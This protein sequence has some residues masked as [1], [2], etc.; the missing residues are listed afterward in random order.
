[1]SAALVARDT[2]KRLNMSINAYLSIIG[3]PRF[4]PLEKRGDKS[5]QSEDEEKETSSKRE[6]PKILENGGPSQNELFFLF[7]FPCKTVEEKEINEKKEER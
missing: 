2:A 5:Y 3:M 4:R 1:M 6:K 7:P